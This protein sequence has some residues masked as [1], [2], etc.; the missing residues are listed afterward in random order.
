M[1]V[2]YEAVVRNSRLVR[3]ALRH[4]LTSSSLPCQPS[5]RPQDLYSVVSNGYTTR[6]K[7]NETNETHIVFRKIT[8]SYRCCTFSTKL[9]LTQTQLTNT[10]KPQR[11]SKREYQSKLDKSTSMRL[12]FEAS[13]EPSAGAQ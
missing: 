9:I 13:I 2:F 12:E 11:T 1:V 8:T 5:T 10:I 7:R 6:T 4:A 3:R